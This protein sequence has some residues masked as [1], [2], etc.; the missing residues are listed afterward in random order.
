[1]L[2]W[3]RTEASKLGF[4]GVI[5]KSNKCADKRLAFVTLRC[6]RNDKYTIPIR[7]MKHNDTCL[8][9]CE[10]PFKLHGYIFENDKQRLNAIC[11]TD[12]YDMCHKLTGHPIACRLMAGEK[13]IVPEM[14]LNMM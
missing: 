3:I 14:T 6:E 10:C 2:Q 7:N 1:M 9:K 5:R 8:R 12:N 13:E 11:G 4:N